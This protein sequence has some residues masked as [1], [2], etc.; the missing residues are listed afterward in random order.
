LQK[1]VKA[2]VATFTERRKEGKKDVGD[3]QK[4]ADK[5]AKEGMNRGISEGRKQSR[6]RRKKRSHYCGGA[7]L[8]LLLK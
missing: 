6:R 1:G 8:G 2:V 7:V 4:G 5:G 3:K